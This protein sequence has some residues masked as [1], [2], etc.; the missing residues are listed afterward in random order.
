MKNKF[1]VEDYI[2]EV[3]EIVNILKC[4]D[5]FCDESVM[6]ENATKQEREANAVWFVK[7]LQSHRSLLTVSIK[8][9]EQN[10]CSLSN[11]FNLIT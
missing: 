7:R 2:L 5:E 1:D 6:P 8:S 11:E 10:I 3:K 9:L 4:F